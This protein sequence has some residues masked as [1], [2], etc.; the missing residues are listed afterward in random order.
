MQ[1]D[2]QL[3]RKIRRN[4]DM[5]AADE[6]ISR[7]YREIYAYVYRQTGDREL[8]MD[9]TQDIFIAI[10]QG[11]GSFDGRRAQFRTWAYRVASNKITD[12]YRSRLHRERQ[13]ESPLPLDDTEKENGLHPKDIAE[14]PHLKGRDVL[15]LLL[16]RDLIRQVMEIIMQYDTDWV[17]I[18]QKKCFEERTFS[19][20][21]HELHLS[22]NTV[23]TRFYSML[24]RV[25]SDL[26]QNE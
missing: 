22:E 1:S 23:K 20:I 16:S 11:I 18:F 15:E 19:E 9:L 24:R 10:L 26:A 8:S 7:Y 5:A 21:A 13:R 2:K 14:H 4:A 3:I 12:Y 25:R 6:L 17:R